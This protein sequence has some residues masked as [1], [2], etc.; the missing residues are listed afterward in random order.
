MSQEP[1]ERSRTDATAA[2]SLSVGGLAPG[3][4]YRM[5][6][7]TGLFANFTIPPT[8]AQLAATCA[9]QG[10][11][12]RAITFTATAASMTFDQ[13]SAGSVAGAQPLGRFPAAG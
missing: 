9:A 4:A 11:G 13:D 3:Q 7:T 2:Y 6:R 10:A 8:A 1:G 5:F 12:C